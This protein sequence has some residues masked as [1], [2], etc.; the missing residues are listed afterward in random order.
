MADRFKR[1][2]IPD[3]PACPECLVG[4]LVWFLFDDGVDKW[5]RWGVWNCDE[6]DHEEDLVHWLTLGATRR[7][8][9]MPDTFGDNPQY[10]ERQDVMSG[11]S[12]WQREINGNSVVR[13]SRRAG[14]YQ[15]AYTQMQYELVR[16]SMWMYEFKG[17]HNSEIFAVIA[18]FW[19]QEFGQTPL[20]SRTVSAWVQ[21][22]KVMRKRG[23]EWP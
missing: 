18:H 3:G 9:T 16:W 1:P 8:H 10:V 2:D 21:T 11:K 5:N 17:W 20:V 6:C 23:L 7:L 12:W 4:K 19:P 22:R 15:V 13:R 14:I